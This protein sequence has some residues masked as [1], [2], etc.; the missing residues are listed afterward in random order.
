MARENYDGY[1]ALANAIVKSAAEDYMK[2]LKALKRNS[3]SRSA[4]QN[5]EDN[6]RF[7]HSAWY[8]VLTDVD[9]D[10][11]IRRMKEAVFHE[12]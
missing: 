3:N 10:Y 1:E 4:V 11:L 2:A 12:S 6:E 9:G 8:S 7:F 5:V